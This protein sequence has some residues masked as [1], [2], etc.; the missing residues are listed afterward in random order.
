EDTAMETQ[1]GAPRFRPP[2]GGKE[3][4][5]RG[6]VVTVGSPLGGL[7]ALTATEAA[8]NEKEKHGRIEDPPTRRRDG[9]DD[10]HRPQVPDPYRA[11][12]EDVRK[13]KEVA[14]WVAAQ[15]RVTNAYLESIP[16][17]NRIRSRLTELWN[18][19][20]YSPPLKIA[21]RYYYSKNDGLQN[22]SVLYVVDKLD[23]EPKVV[24]DPNKWS[25]DGT[26]ALAGLSFSEDGKYLAYGLA[27]A[28][29]DWVTWKV[30][31]LADHHPLRD[32]IK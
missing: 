5:M 20:R 25:K 15:N 7:L 3:I 1:A 6:V 18:Y 13:S 22:Q 29:S 21:G 23:G 2:S 19:A 16:Q 30:L 31:S 17:R 10:Y 24:L 27:E 28:G 8:H 11:L 12:E 4:A 32:E 9:V 26:V 14:E